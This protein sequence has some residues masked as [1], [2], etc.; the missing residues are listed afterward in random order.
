MKILSSRR[1]YYV[2]RISI[3]L[4]MIALIAG[5]AGC[6]FPPAPRD[7]Q[8]RTWYDLNAIRDNLNGHHILMNDLDSTS[9]GYEEL[10]GPT[11]NVGKGWHP[12]VGAGENPIGR[13]AGRG[14]GE[15]P[16]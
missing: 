5:M 9:A 8:I 12:I 10:A 14:R 16:V 15:I 3:L 7:L 1:R 6:L 11:A 13:A 4:I 2:V